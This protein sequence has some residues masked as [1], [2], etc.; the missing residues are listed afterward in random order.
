MSADPCGIPERIQYYEA[1][2]TTKNQDTFAMDSN[3]YKT[4]SN[5]MTECFNIERVLTG[6]KGKTYG[7]RDEYRTSGKAARLIH[8][9]IISMADE[10]LRSDPVLWIPSEVWFGFLM[11]QVH[12]IQRTQI[13]I[14]RKHPPNLGVLTSILNYMLHS[15]TTTPIVFDLHLREYLALLEYRNVLETQQDDITVLALMGANTKV[16]RAR[17][18]VRLEISRADAEHES[19]EFPL[20]RRP[21][22]VRLK[23]A[24]A[25]SPPSIMKPW[26]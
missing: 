11:R 18:A 15:T 7:M 9:S 10:Y 8:G 23:S 19:E 26:M 5:Y 2:R 24:I 4:S 6:S 21:S 3:A 12:E 16:Q 22:W 14:A 25:S 13:A 17:T 1:V 20:G